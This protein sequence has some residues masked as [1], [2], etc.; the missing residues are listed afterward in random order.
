MVASETS[1]SSS[2]TSSN[3]PGLFKLLTTRLQ[4]ADRYEGQY[5]T[6]KHAKQPAAVARTFRHGQLSNESR[7]TPSDLC[8]VQSP[9]S[10]DP[11]KLGDTGKIS[12]GTSKF[13]F[14]YEEVASGQ[15]PE[16]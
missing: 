7:H 8:V 5:E 16:L 14:G 6:A 4:A 12:T 1:P 10:W 15:K 9:P 13:F 2:C 11:S 3:F